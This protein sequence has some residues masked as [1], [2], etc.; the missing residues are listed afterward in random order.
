MCYLFCN[1]KDA[2]IEIVTACWLLKADLCHFKT[3]VI[4][5]VLLFGK[6]GCIKSIIYFRP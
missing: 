3:S 5:V 1:E 4:T 6:L 2:K